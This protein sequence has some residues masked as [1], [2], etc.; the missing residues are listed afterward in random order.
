MS[1]VPQGSALGLILFNILINYT[2][3]RAKCTLCKF[4]DDTKLW[5]SVRTPEGQDATQRVL[6]RLEQWANMNLMKFNKSKFK[7][8]HLGR[9]NP[10]Y[11]YKLEDKRIKWSSAEKHL[12]YW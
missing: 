4:A 11:H 12:R 3:S 8:L 1:D 9:G 10:H 5:G 2:D 6:D 7:I